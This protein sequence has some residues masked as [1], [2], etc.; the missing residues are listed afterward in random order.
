MIM[1]NAKPTFVGTIIFASLIVAFL[2]TF[3]FSKEA[4]AFEKYGN[5][6]LKG[7]YAVI[8][9]EQGGGDGTGKSLLPEAA[10]GTA[11]FDGAGKVKGFLTWNM[12]DPTTA[13]PARLILR[14]HPYTGTYSIDAQG[15]GGATLVLDLG[16]MGKLRLKVDLC[17]T[18]ATKEKVAMEVHAIATKLTSSG[19]LPIM[20]MQK[21][22]Q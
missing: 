15:F 21:R 4:E 6:S 20:K 1:R 9:V 17:V 18:N 5:H 16:D 11:T 10:M 12:P 13:Y 3:L 19:A 7:P 14:K 2:T 8:G 22:E